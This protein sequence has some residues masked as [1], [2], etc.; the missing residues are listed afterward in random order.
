MI[1][2]I[3]SLGGFALASKPTRPLAREALLGGSPVEAKNRVLIV[4]SCN[5][6]FTIRVDSIPSIGQ[7]R[8]GE[9]MVK[10]FGGKGANQAVAARRAGAL[11]AFASMVGQDDEGRATILN[12]VY[13]DID[14]RFVRKVAG[15]STGAAFIVVDRAGDNVIV[16]SPGASARFD[17]EAIDAL[18]DDLFER[19]AVLATVLEVPLE[20]VSRAIVRAWEAGIIVLLNPAPPRK[21]LGRDLLSKV[22]VLT[23]NR[24]EAQVLSGVRIHSAADE[25]AACK[26]LLD[27]G[28]GAVVLTLGERG[29]LLAERLRPIQRFRALAIK[30]VDAVGAGDAFSGALAAGLAQGLPL[31]KS[32]ERANAAAALAVTSR[33]AQAGLPTKEQIDRALVLLRS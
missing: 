30:A 12:L 9:S 8:I 18:P 21:D 27:L 11:V 5:V 22:D 20:A 16:V 13:E 25:E 6:D 33:G 14:I 1:S 31:T 32:V 26:A 15:S 3:G 17:K 23:P 28:P 7:T 29:C 2:S 19:S 4:G 10:S 24:D